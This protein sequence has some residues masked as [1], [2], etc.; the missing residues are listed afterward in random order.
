MAAPRAKTV[1]SDL[2]CLSGIDGGGGHDGLGQQLA[3]EHDAV[4][5]VERLA[6]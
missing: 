1:W 4:A 5:L 2:T 6:R 3:A